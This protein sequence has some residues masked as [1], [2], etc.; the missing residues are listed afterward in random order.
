MSQDKLVP[1]MI[2]IPKQY[3]DILRTKAAKINVENPNAVTS[4]A[5]IA[6]EI[7]CKNLDQNQM[8]D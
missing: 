2:S 7:L 1:L 6:R 8:E 4:A 5:Q 3:K